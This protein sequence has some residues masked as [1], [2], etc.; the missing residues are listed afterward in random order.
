MKHVKTPNF[1]SLND[2]SAGRGSAAP[3]LERRKPGKPEW[4]A[5]SMSGVTIRSIMS[6]STVKVGTT[7][8]SMNP[9]GIDIE[10]LQIVLLLFWPI[11]FQNSALAPSL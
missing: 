8:K 11:A 2:L 1:S 7:M 5:S 10:K 3:H 9:G 4:E 6:V